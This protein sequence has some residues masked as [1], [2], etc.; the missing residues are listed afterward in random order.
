MDGEGNRELPTPFFSL[1][2]GYGY[3][4][5]EKSRTKQKQLCLWVRVCLVRVKITSENVFFENE[6]DWLVWKILFSENWNPLT[7]KKSLWPRKLFSISIFISKYFRKERDINVCT[8]YVIRIINYNNK[9][10]LRP[11]LFVLFEKSNILREHHLLSCLP[12]KN[13]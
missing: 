8:N 13:V 1:G 7:E 3:E 5:R 10:S 4:Y 9:Y 11:T 6:A 12:Y 2:Y